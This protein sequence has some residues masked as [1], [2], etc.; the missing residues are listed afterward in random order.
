MRGVASGARISRSN[1]GTAPAGVEDVLSVPVRDG[2]G[3]GRRAQ[4]V[5]LV[6]RL[7]RARRPVSAVPAGS[8]RAGTARASRVGASAVQVAAVALDAAVGAADRLTEAGAADDGL[9]A[10]QLSRMGSLP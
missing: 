6:Q 9:V 7:V 2:H 3:A 4:R 10:F 8:G 5:L 1:Q